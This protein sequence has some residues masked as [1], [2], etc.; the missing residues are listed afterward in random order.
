MGRDLV[1]IT[2]YD[3][4]DLLDRTPL[5]LDCGHTI[6]GACCGKMSE[7]QTEEFLLCPVCR[8]EC[9][10]PVD[11]LPK[12]YLV[13][14][15]IEAQHAPTKTLLDGWGIA[16]GYEKWILDSG[17]L[18]LCHILS[19]GAVAT[20]DVWV[21]RFKGQQVAV[22]AI[23]ITHA[24]TKLVEKLKQEVLVLMRIT[25]HCRHTCRWLGV[26][27]MEGKFCIVMKLYKSNL[28]QLVRQQAA[29]KLP[30]AWSLLLGLD[31]LRALVE[32]HRLGVI[33]A[34]LKP[35]NVLVDEGEEVV[36]AD[37]GVSLL[38]THTM[39]GH[40]QSSVQGTPNYM[41]PEQFHAP[42]LLTSK[43][44]IWS[45]ACTLLFILTGEVPWQGCGLVQLCTK[46]G[47][48]GE[49]PPIP[50]NLPTGLRALLTECLNKDPKERPSASQLVHQM[51]DLL[52]ELMKTGADKV[53]GLKQG[54]RCGSKEAASVGDREVECP[55]EC[56]PLEA[57]LV[58]AGGEEGHGKGADITE[59]RRIEANDMEA[60][61]PVASVSQAATS[62]S[63]PLVDKEQDIAPLQACGQACSP[64]MGFEN[65][66][67]IEPPV[68]P[69]PSLS[70]RPHEGPSPG[71]DGGIAEASPVLPSPAALHPGGGCR[72]PLRRR[73]RRGRLSTCAPA[74][75]I[76][77]H[78][79]PIPVD[80]L[81]A[82]RAAVFQHMIQSIAARR[83]LQE[84]RGSRE[85]GEERHLD[86]MEG[87]GHPQPVEIDQ[88]LT[89]DRE[90]EEV[91]ATA[92]LEALSVFEGNAL[93]P[94]MESVANSVPVERLPRSTSGGSQSP[95]CNSTGSLGRAAVA[96]GEDFPHPLIGDE[97]LTCEPVVLE[98]SSKASTSATSW[99]KAD[100][101]SATD[102]LN[103]GSGYSAGNYNHAVE[104]MPIEVSPRDP[105][106]HCQSEL[107][108]KRDPLDMGTL[109]SE[110]VPLTPPVES[111]LQATRDLLSN[112]SPGN[113]CTSTNRMTDSEL[114]TASAATQEGPGSRHARANMLSSIPPQEIPLKNMRPRN[115]ADVDAE[116]TSGA[117]TLT[118]GSCPSPFCNSGP[119]VP[120]E[121]E[122]HGEMEMCQ[123]TSGYLS[124]D[125][126]PGDLLEEPAEVTSRLWWSDPGPSS[127]MSRPR[128]PNEPALSRN[129]SEC[130]HLLAQ[131]PSRGLSD[132]A[133]TTSTS[134]QSCKDDGQASRYRA[135]AAACSIGMASF[136]K[137][138]LCS[139]SP[140]LPSIPIHTR[141]MSYLQQHRELLRAQLMQEENSRQTAMVHLPHFHTT[142]GRGSLMVTRHR[143]HSQSSLAECQ[144]G[145]DARGE[146][147]QEVQ[148]RL[149]H[150]GGYRGSA[151]QAGLDGNFGRVKR[152]FSLPR[153][154]NNKHVGDNGTAVLLPSHSDTSPPLPDNKEGTST[155]GVQRLTGSEVVQ[156]HTKERLGSTNGI[157]ASDK[158]VPQE[159]ISCE[160]AH[161]IVD[162]LT[163]RRQRA[164]WSGEEMLVAS[165]PGMKCLDPWVL[166]GL[167]PRWTL[168]HGLSQEGASSVF[169]S[170]SSQVTGHD[171]GSHSPHKPSQQSLSYIRLQGGSGKVAYTPEWAVWRLKVALA[172]LEGIPADSLDLYLDGTVLEAGARISRYSGISQGAVKLCAREGGKRLH[173]WVRLNNGRLSQVDCQDQ[174]TVEDLK[175]ALAAKEDI[176]VEHQ[177]LIFNAKLLDNHRLLQEYDIHDGS[178]VQYVFRQRKGTPS[179]PC[180][181]CEDTS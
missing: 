147:L 166:G 154:A 54:Q 164:G 134:Y 119:T 128:S 94:S 131:R 76:D 85:D 122:L 179:P 143:A 139:T 95:T 103:C 30:L 20:G 121:H 38:V 12:N 145:M 117:T 3:R 99:L 89:C 52:E 163:P 86:E 36:L 77:D 5:I 100:L 130:W 82:G 32:V 126:Q 6:C 56:L 57:P 115:E 59:V 70:T 28:V 168:E 106:S 151:Q 141:S 111:H 175:V 91:R 19:P 118:G 153:M 83:V 44:D 127:S 92:P 62:L 80:V 81:A 8:Q 87:L 109:F 97:A 96:S 65:N 41:A 31:L 63:S 181:P 11:Q 171:A 178:V 124:L 129:L 112:S 42:A 173:V 2:C 64:P 170:S 152:D 14:S 33:V 120:I 40:L 72:G 93:T 165:L 29:G 101:A 47:L 67:G 66:R 78:G 24:A 1:C 123:L 58:L 162:V 102:H 15:L 46:V 74:A 9:Y 104:L 108:S 75:I 73:A 48:Q 34:D 107:P 4:F 113:A 55:A 60:A 79:P 39:G 125:L 61:P 25:D 176:E 149:E 35:E 68:C 69:E 177:R 144:S 159:A 43:T 114:G 138:P 146:P 105:A 45:F 157:C 140:C 137:A 10:T 53:V 148:S 16:E 88:Q 26:T 172:H 156:E 116:V 84:Q 135:P 158:A 22:K 155:S 50:P 21:G 18:E 51:R 180:P 23:C 110:S 150:E 71:G 7:E 136:R 161:S 174:S 160:A 98:S 90:E 27:L 17:Q 37:F 132:E 13:L 167:Q 169:P 49:G 142:L 133:T